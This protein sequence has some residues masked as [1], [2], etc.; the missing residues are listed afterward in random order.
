MVRTSKAHRLWLLCLCPRVCACRHSRRWF[1]L[2]GTQLFY[3]EDE[4]HSRGGASQANGCLMVAGSTLRA[5]EPSQASGRRHAF[6]LTQPCSSRMYIMDA[7]S[8]QSRIDWLAALVKAGAL[9][10]EPQTR[11]VVKATT[12]VEPVP[13]AAA[14]AAQQ[15]MFACS[16]HEGWLLKLGGASQRHCCCYCCCRSHSAFAPAFSADSAALDA[17]AAI[18]C[19]GVQKTSWQAR[20][21][22]L[23]G[24]HLVYWKTP[25]AGLQSRTGPVEEHEAPRGSI[26]LEGAVLS[27][28][29][30]SFALLGHAHAFTILP[31]EN[32]KSSLFSSLFGE[33][34]KRYTFVAR[35]AADLQQWVAALTA[36][37][38]P[39]RAHA[40]PCTRAS[41]TLRGTHLF[42][43]VTATVVRVCICSQN[44]GR[45]CDE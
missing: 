21:F 18:I 33:T 3:Y 5:L 7:P 10:D 30:D 2:H 22:V 44:R 39:R 41:V 15:P 23:L 37:Y 19:S 24:Q 16:S 8:E 14:A 34:L 29:Q 31:R 6:G 4:P 32:P 25:M 35:D 17:C 27:I 43:V 20:Y 11:S 40:D 9:V 38:T 36:K 26:H 13:L 45:P 1:S 42:V 28:E 12:V